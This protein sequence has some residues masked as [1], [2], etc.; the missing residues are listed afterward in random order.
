[1]SGFVIFPWPVFG[2][3]NR[4]KRMDPHG[5]RLCYFISKHLQAG[6]TPISL[7]A[8]GDSLNSPFLSGLAG[9]CAAA[10]PLGA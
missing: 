4:R 7:D 5:Y 9:S 2:G 1:M 6:S 10:K 3:R 8:M